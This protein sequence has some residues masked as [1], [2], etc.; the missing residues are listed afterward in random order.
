MTVNPLEAGLA[1]FTNSL[2]GGNLNK[3]SKST[4][5][6][7]EKRRNNPRVKR[8][9]ERKL[10]SMQQALLGR[11]FKLAGGKVVKVR[12]VDVENQCRTKTWAEANDVNLL[13][14]ES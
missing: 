2:S 8:T 13:D 10:G 7:G 4:P 11:N 14:N 6:C 5:T 9:K 3:S 12:E 1:A